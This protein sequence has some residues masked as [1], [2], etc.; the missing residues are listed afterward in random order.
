MGPAAVA[1]CDGWPPRRSCVVLREKLRLVRSA[2]LR[3]V[4]TDQCAVSPSP[5]PPA[6]LPTGRGQTRQTGSIIYSKLA[7]IRARRGHW[8]VGCSNAPPALCYIPAMGVIEKKRK[9]KESLI[10][11]AFWCLNKKKKKNHTVCLPACLPSVSYGKV[12]T[13]SHRSLLEMSAAAASAR[14]ICS[15]FGAAWQ[16]YIVNRLLRRGHVAP[17]DVI[18]GLHLF[19]EKIPPICFSSNSPPMVLV[20]SSAF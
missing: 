18:N 19:P 9:E 1:G 12:P 7:A 17:S 15:S 5:R 2:A 10:L 11:Q 8:D 3:G 13:T 4:H 20:F 6:R 16:L 14:H